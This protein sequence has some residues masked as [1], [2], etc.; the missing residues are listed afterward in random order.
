MRLA[1]T[2]E[3]NLTPGEVDLYVLA[4]GVG[5]AAAR[6]IVR[7][8]T[9]KNRFGQTAEYRYLYLAYRAGDKIKEHYIAK[10]ADEKV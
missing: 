7:R 10:L 1:R 3:N 5:R 8:R 4:R 9:R 6:L 2:V